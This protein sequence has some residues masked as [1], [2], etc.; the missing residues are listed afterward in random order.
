MQIF[1]VT[2]LSC[3]FPFLPFLYRETGYGQVNSCSQRSKILELRSLE[4]RA[5]DLSQNNFRELLPC[6]CK[7]NWLFCYQTCKHSQSSHMLQNLLP[8]SLFFDVWSYRWNRIRQGNIGKSLLLITSLGN[9]IWSF[10]VNKEFEALIC[11]FFSSSFVRAAS[12]YHV[13]V[14]LG[15]YSH[16][17]QWLK[18]RLQWKMFCWKIQ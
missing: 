1:F 16:W 4:I 10:S 15:I 13:N 18:T 8:Q 14:Q 17:T 9:Q 11:I 5:L 12:L 7:P 6:S 3:L 2:L